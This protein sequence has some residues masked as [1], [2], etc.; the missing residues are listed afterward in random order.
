MLVDIEMVR[1]MK[2]R[3]A[4]INRL[5]LE[6]IVWVKDGKVCEFPEK[7]VGYWK[8]TRLNNTDLP[9]YEDNEEIIEDEK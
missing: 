6:D 5:D 1:M 8:L 9:V 3:I 2:A 4:D 7:T